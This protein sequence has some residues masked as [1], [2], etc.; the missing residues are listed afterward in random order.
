MHM[1][2]HSEAYLNQHIAAKRERGRR[3]P[4]IRHQPLNHMKTLSKEWA[5]SKLPNEDGQEIGAGCPASDLFGPWK[6]WA[7]TDNMVGKLVVV[8]WVYPL[9][10]PG[11]KDVRVSL[12][13]KAQWDDELRTVVVDGKMPGD[14]AQY[15]EFGW[16]N[17]QD[18]R[19]GRA[20]HC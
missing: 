5:E 20:D 4:R 1:H 8:A 7:P 15:F 6:P 11:G 19:T 14:D 9:L 18:Q 17:G 13:G 10:G 16:P 12:H 2:M 3:T